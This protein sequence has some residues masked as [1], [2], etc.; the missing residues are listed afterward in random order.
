M[1]RFYLIRHG[2]TYGNTLGRYIG[3][4]DESLRKE[5]MLEL[6]EKEYPKADLIF[7]SPLNRCVETAKIIY[8]NQQI[9]II[10]SLSE[11]DFGEFENKNAKEL[12]SNPKYQEWIDSY[13]TLPFPGGE[14]QV[15]F[16][17]RCKKGMQ[18]IIRQCKEQDI[19]K[20]ALVVHGGTIMSIMSA[21]GRPEEEYFFW[22]IGN[23]NGYELEI[24]TGEEQKDAM[25]I[26]SGGDG[27]Y[28]GLDSGRSS[29]ALSSGETGGEINHGNRT[30]YKRMFS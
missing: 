23:A 6:E 4:T 17:N 26:D 9:S 18:E 15:E 7:S 29:V 16:R 14:S 24:E 27:I 1:I 12:A 22:Q 13:G 3:V 11:C 30:N 19:Q 10:K 28:A 5:S 21:Y 25:D 20:A 2:K 8:P